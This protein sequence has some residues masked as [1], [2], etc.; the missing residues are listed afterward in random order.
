MKY[1]CIKQK[2]NYLPALVK[3]YE[4]MISKVVFAGPD[5]KS[6]VIAL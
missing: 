6:T 4:D 2:D 3:L 5:S 1:T